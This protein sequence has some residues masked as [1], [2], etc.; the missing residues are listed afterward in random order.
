MINIREINLSDFRPLNGVLLLIKKYFQL[1]FNSKFSFLILEA[2]T[3]FCNS[4]RVKEIVN[5][6]NKYNSQGLF[7]QTK[8]NTGPLFGSLFS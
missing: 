8:Y 3:G 7:A 2:L 5:E 1:F 6:Q 4:N